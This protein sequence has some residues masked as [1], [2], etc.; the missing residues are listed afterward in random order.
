MSLDRKRFARLASDARHLGVLRGEAA[1]SWVIDGNTSE[2]EARAILQGYEDGDPEV[3]DLQPSPLS[4]E[5]AGDPTP[6]SL[7]AELGVHHLPYGDKTDSE[8][9]SDLADA[10]EEG[11]GEG[12]W[13]EV[14]RAA[15]AKLGVRF[16]KTKPFE[17]GRSRS[18]GRAQL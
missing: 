17:V 12:F 18:N 7:M 15:R 10:Y 3:M 8:E 5:W 1:G 6:Q 4:G 2:A 13:N 9:E 16:K 11:F 14:Q